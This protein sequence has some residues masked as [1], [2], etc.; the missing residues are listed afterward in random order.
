MF[1]FSTGIILLS[2]DT[3]KDINGLSLC[4]RTKKN[5][6]I[7]KL[8]ILTNIKTNIKK[9]N[10]EISF[11]LKNVLTILTGKNCFNQFSTRMAAWLLLTFFICLRNQLSSIH[12]ITRIKEYRCLRN[13]IHQKIDS[14]NEWL[15]PSASF[16]A[17]LGLV[18]VLTLENAIY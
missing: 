17:K 13:V 12:S 6:D 4:K 2:F 8:I 3:M 5:T 18:F 7:P 9:R 16:M 1:K 11:R 14:R 15:L 10:K